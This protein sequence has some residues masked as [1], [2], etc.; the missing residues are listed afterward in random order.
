MEKVVTASEIRNIDK[1]AIKEVGIPGIVLMERAG[2]TV[3]GTVIDFL[4]EN[5]GDKVLVFCGKGNNGGDG[6][7]AARELF[8]EGFD[9]NV[10]VF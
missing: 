10:Y 2:L 5:N 9:V 3:A 1:R 4:D 6:L 8:N 7:V